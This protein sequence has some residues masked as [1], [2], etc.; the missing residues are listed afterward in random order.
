MRFCRNQIL[1]IV[2]LL[3]PVFYLIDLMSA[4]IVGANIEIETGPS[5]I[6]MSA[7]SQVSNGVS[8]SRHLS[9]PD[10]VRIDI[11]YS[12]LGAVL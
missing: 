12:P 9:K 3:W 7:L 5:S 6:R 2:R 8:I 11:Q 4:L 10:G 1:R